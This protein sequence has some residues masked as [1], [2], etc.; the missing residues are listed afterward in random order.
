MIL[1]G[2]THSTATSSSSINE[3]SLSRML[4]NGPVYPA[5]VKRDSSFSRE[6]SATLSTESI[7]AGHNFDDFWPED[8]SLCAADEDEDRSQSLSLSEIETSHESQEDD[9]KSVHR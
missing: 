7:L 5:P 9:N 1:D 2:K 3:F 6:L 8:D 4:R